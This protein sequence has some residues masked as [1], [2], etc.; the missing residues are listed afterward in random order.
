[1]DYRHGGW[2]ER[3]QQDRPKAG[4]SRASEIMDISDERSWDQPIEKPNQEENGISA[5]PENVDL[6][7]TSVMLLKRPKFRYRIFFGPYALDVHEDVMIKYRMIQGAVFT[8]SDLEDVVSAD[9]R[10]RGY[11][12]ALLYLSRK[13]RTAHEIGVR[14]AEKG[15]SQDT[16]EKVLE[17]LIRERFVDDAAYAQEW[18]G[19]R[20]K[21]RGKGKM[22]V[23]HE[24]RQKGVSKPLIEEALNEVSEED[25]FDSA[26]QIAVKKWKAT[27]GEPL[28]KK[29]KTG[30]FLMR[31]GYSGGLVSRVISELSRQDGV[32]GEEDWEEEYN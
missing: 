19:Q 26:L 9:E 16:I 27:K 23:R 20:V 24:L 4:K 3:Q 8:K 25:E 7:I 18:A 15:W 6:T 1:M 17:R 21:S 28:E 29:R 22:W 32:N 11:A 2:G 5:M 14:L 30:T 10:Q 12:D 13:P 31:R